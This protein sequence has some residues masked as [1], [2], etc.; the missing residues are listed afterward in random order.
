MK[1]IF[2]IIIC[3]KKM[4]GIRSIAMESLELLYSLHKEIGAGP[5]WP[6]FRIF[7]YH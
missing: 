2:V 1:Y 5:L 7:F 4:P 3:I 6:P